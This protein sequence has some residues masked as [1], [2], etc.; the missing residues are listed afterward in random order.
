M[1]QHALPGA[2]GQIPPAVYPEVVTRGGARPDAL[3][4][5]ELITA[6]HSR[7]A[8]TTAVGEGLSSQVHYEQRIEEV[9]LMEELD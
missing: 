9:R 1:A 6:G 8:D 4:A 3:K 2:D 7:V 5:A